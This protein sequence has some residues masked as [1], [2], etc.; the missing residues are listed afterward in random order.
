MFMPDQTYHLSADEMT[1]FLKGLEDTMEPYSTH[2]HRYLLLMEKMNKRCFAVSST[3][4]QTIM[5]SV[6]MFPDLSKACEDTLHGFA[7]LTEIQAELLEVAQDINNDI[8]QIQREYINLLKSL[9]G[10]CEKAE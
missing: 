10:S 8:A 3:G 7:D 1:V 9:N 6:G 2:C 4:I 5:Q